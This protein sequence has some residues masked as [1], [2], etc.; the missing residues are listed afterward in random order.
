MFS[1]IILAAGL[2]S[3]MNNIKKQFCEI[4][5]KIIIEFSVETFLKAGASEIVIAVNSSRLSDMQSFFKTNSKVKLV[6]GGKTRQHSAENAFLVC[7]K[8]NSLVL[9]HDAARPFVQVEAVKKLIEIARKTKAA[10]LASFATDTIKLVKDQKV[11][12][13]LNREEIALIQ[14]PQAFDMQLYQRAID[15][16]K[17]NSK[18]FTDDC[19]L[20]EKLGVPVAVVENSKLN[21]KITNPIDLDLATLLASKFK[22]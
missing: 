1:A 4:N 10:T 18:T 22:F 5:G 9:I 14:T 16:S 2:G 21:F 3:R 20:V 6:A 13:T 19:Q 12:K 8:T 15:F 17:K 11:Q 7:S